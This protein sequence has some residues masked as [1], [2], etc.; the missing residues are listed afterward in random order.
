MVSFREILSGL[1]QLDLDGQ[2]PV[3][4]HASLSAFGE[5][6]GGVDTLL[7]AV[8]GIF[9]AVM[10]P[11]FTE[12]AMIIPEEGPADNGISY[13]SGKD[14]NLMAEVFSPNLPA[15][16]LMGVLAETLRNRAGVKRSTHPILSFS[17]INVDQALE[18]Q[19]QHTP[20]API[21]VLAEQ[22]GWVLL[23]GTNHTV[24]TCIH[25]AEWLAGRKQFV[26]WAILP[27]S[28]TECPVFP[29]C[30]DGFD[31]IAPNFE[32]ITHQV[33]IGEALVRAI[34]LQPMIQVVVDLLHHDPLALLCQRPECG[35]CDSVRRDVEKRNA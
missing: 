34:P 22:E 35:R 15:D 30:S 32:G 8:F 1:R 33:Q 13:G 2:H 21:G 26:R 25:Y 7:G 23:I 18:V 28:I 12:R 3:I 31:S 27:G 24:N 10:V 16:K 6:R 5:I 20:L 4:A 19:T 17:G 29:G 11:T 9:N 14:R